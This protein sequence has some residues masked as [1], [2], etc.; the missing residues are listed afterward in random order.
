MACGPTFLL[1]LRRRAARG[2]VA[3]L[4][5]HGDGRDDA[6][7]AAQTP[8]LLFLLQV[9]EDVLGSLVGARH[10]PRGEGFLKR[11]GVDQ[12]A[13]RWSSG[14]RNVGGSEQMGGG[15]GD[16]KISTLN[17]LGTC[18]HSYYRLLRSNWTTHLYSNSPPAH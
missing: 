8:L 3:G 15:G 10:R 13:Q 6:G 5:S 1:L 17:L 14:C 16:A 12:T 4:L 7:L 2:L 9:L 18:V 11:R